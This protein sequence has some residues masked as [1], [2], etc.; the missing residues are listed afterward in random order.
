MKIYKCKDY[1]EV[2]KKAANI[3]IQNMI[4][5]PNII[6]GLATGSSPIG[7]YNYLIKA[8]Q[9]GLISFKEV[10]TYNLDEYVGID[11]LHPQSYSS[12]MNRVLFDHVDINKNNIHIPNSNSI[13]INDLANE[14]N[15]LLFG[16]QR[17][18][19]ILGIGEN[20]HIGFNEPGSSVSNQS[21]VTKLS[22]ETRKANARFFSSLEEVPKYAVTMGIKNIMFSK[23][24][25]L[26]ATG[27]NK[28]KA[29]YNM[30]YG[31]ITE[32][33]PASFLQLH[34]DV[35]VIIDEEAA[36]ELHMETEC[37]EF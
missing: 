28:A 23:K 10:K 27:N 13:D 1:D 32:E 14:Y 22:E 9:D 21:F 2:S 36:L 34:P 11:K 12:F 5:K 31:K 16:N 18:L 33:V 8:Y 25:I 35:V 20:A 17:D 7:I 37:L 19:Q 26:V 4:Q 3:V 29:V 15:K 24:I 6:L 30:V